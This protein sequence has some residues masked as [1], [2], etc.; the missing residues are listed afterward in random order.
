MKNKFILFVLILFASGVAS[1]QNFTEILGRP[2]TTTITV[3]ILFDQQAEVY[4]ELGTSPGNYTITT[5]TFTAV[6]DSAFEADFPSLS[7]NTKYYYKTR[8][9][10]AGTSGIFL[11]GIE[12][13]FHTQRPA[14][15]TYKFAIEADPHL[16]TN[17]NYSSYTLTLQNILAKNPDFLID[18][19]DNFMSEKLPVQSQTQNEITNRHRLY[20]PFYSTACHSVP[21]YLVLG[22]HEGENGWLLNGSANSMPVIAANT[23]KL[24]YPNPIPNSFYS[25]DTIPENF[26]GLRENYY[27]WEW[28][29]ALFVVLD[30]YWYTVSKPDWG[31]TLGED[32]YNWY[33]NTVTNSQAKFKFVFCH[34]LVGGDGTNGRGGTEFA[35][36]WEMGGYNLDSTWGFT[37]FRPGWV[38]PVHT[39]MVE[40]NVN[41]FFHGHDHFY[42]KQDLDGV[43]YQEV[44]QPSSKNIT[45]I[46]GLQYGYT[47]G[48]FLPSRGY[49]LVTITD[50]SAKVDYIR[51]YLPSE[52]NTTRH[53]GDIGHTYTLTSITTGLTENDEFSGFT[54]EQNYPNPFNQ[55]TTI[56]YQLQTTNVVQ[57]ILYDILGRE[58]RTLVN[59]NQ[60]PGNYSVFMK[61]GELNLKEG[62]YF[63]K[64]NCG[65]YSKSLKMVYYK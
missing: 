24:F 61:P 42:G 31:W 16:D 35:H 29:N 63:Y 9:R 33:K 46:S 14:G 57:L 3:S 45:N 34:Q 32:Q 53:N 55:E 2:T 65:N 56:K 22:N 52:E 47:N 7:P 26:V 17:T 43:V 21:L 8:Y 20:R 10:L 13:T 49:L 40:N 54:L 23:R 50:S 62:I 51:T 38:K 5:S 4:W 64:L 36:L 58:I 25:G 15:S 30:P 44:P 28:G 60:N 27:S 59:Q 48:I 41:I 6:S 18:L 1:G 12:H 19:G 11:S 39:I 37:S